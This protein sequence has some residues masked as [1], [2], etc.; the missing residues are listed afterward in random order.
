MSNTEGSPIVKPIENQMYERQ[1]GL[2]AERTAD[3]IRPQSAGVNRQFESRR[4]VQFIQPASMESTQVNRRTELRRASR[5]IQQEPARVYQQTELRPVQHRT[6]SITVEHQT[7]LRPDIHET[8][9]TRAQSRQSDYQVQSSSAEYQP[10][11]SVEHQ[12]QFGSGVYETQPIRSQSDY[13]A[14]PSSAAYQP[15]SSA[16][17]QYDPVQ[18]TGS[19]AKY[20]G[21]TSQRSS[22]QRTRYATSRQEYE[23]VYQG[24]GYGSG[25]Q[26]QDYGSGYQGHAYNLGNQGETYGPGYQGQ[27]YNSGYQG[28]A[29]NSGYQGQGYGSG[30][31]PQSSAMDYL[32]YMAMF[33][34]GL[35]LNGMF[36]GISDIINPE[37][38]EALQNS[39]REARERMIKERKAAQNAEGTQSSRPG[40]GNSTLPEQTKQTEGVS[41][42]QTKSNMSYKSEVGYTKI[43]SSNEIQ[44]KARG[45]LKDNLKSA[46]SGATEKSSQAKGGFKDNSKSAQPGQ[47]RNEYSEIRA[48]EQSSQAKGGS[49]DNLKS[50][51]PVQFGNEYIETKAAGQLGQARSEIS[52]Q[53]IVKSQQEIPPLSKMAGQSQM[54]TPKI[55][56]V[57]YK[58]GIRTNKVITDQGQTIQ[59]GTTQITEPT[60]NKTPQESRI[61]KKRQT[62]SKIKKQVKKK[63]KSITQEGSQTQNKPSQILETTDLQEVDPPELGPDRAVSNT[64]TV[65]SNTKTGVSNTKSY[66]SNTKTGVSNT[67]TGVSNT[68]SYVSNTKTGVSNT[69]TGVFNT[70]SDVSKTKSGLHYRKPGVSKPSQ[71]PETTDLQE[72][73]PPEVGPD[74][75]V[76]NTKTGVP[77]T[78]SDLS[79]TKTGVFNTKSGVSNKKSG[80]SNIVSGVSQTGSIEHWEPTY[81]TDLNRVPLYKQLPTNVVDSLYQQPASDA[82]RSHSRPS[83]PNYQSN[84]PVPNFFKGEYY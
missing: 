53:A 54:K 3:I 47:V 38:L 81:L 58:N 12:T 72:V 42:Q 78:K 10:R 50:V 68:K 31:Q 45:G 59:T 52:R 64:K 18:Q 19:N 82:I 14:Q 20:T 77:K 27:T 84:V 8:Q 65:V 43:A 60:L 17:N 26:G 56:F 1:G 55:I 32:P 49:R 21:G 57:L 48:A 35:G 29:Y 67:K 44:S 74:R 66:V 75:A 30:Y 34:N 4:A 5:F 16:E 9:P 83:K 22:G 41:S 73:E 80:V 63:S 6:E 36:E 2:R 76:S 70:K 33:G 69:K 62:F 37:R 79:N 23:P 51:Q 39:R 24:E 61:E 15:R 28:Q 7:Q 46:Q 71:I 11:R 25:Y 40:E 13:Q